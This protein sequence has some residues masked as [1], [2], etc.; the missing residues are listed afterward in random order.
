M[1]CVALCRHFASTGSK[2]DAWIILPVGL[3]CHFNASK[4]VFE[5]RPQTQLIYSFHLVVP[6]WPFFL[7]WFPTSLYYNYALYYKCWEPPILTSGMLT[8]DRVFP[9][10][11][12]TPA[13]YRTENCNNKSISCYNQ[14]LKGWK[15]V[16]HTTSFCEN[17][18][19]Q[20]IIHF[21]WWL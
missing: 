2:H 16:N 1:V 19:L 20:C 15:E 14:S 11:P 21:H 17:W 10:L 9:W 7:W 6:N 3:R 18:V 8:L 5:L 12:V 4:N 13:L